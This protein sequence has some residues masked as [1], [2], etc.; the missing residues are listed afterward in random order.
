MKRTDGL[1]ILDTFDGSQCYST[2]VGRRQR[3]VLVVVCIRM[4]LFFI[5]MQQQLVG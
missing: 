5:H 1:C 2:V 3:E 4:T